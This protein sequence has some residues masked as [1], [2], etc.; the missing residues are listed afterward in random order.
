[1]GVPLVYNGQSGEWRTMRDMQCPPPSDS[2][3]V[4]MAVSTLY[5]LQLID[6]TDL[7]RLQIQ[8]TLITKR[9]KKKDS[10]S[11]FFPNEKKNTHIIAHFR[12]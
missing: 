6:R 3:F 4:T 10:P 1:M 8:K 7:P 2:E 9:E 11:P 5:L 12:I